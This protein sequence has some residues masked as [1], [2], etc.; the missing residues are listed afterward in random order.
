MTEPKVIIVRDK[1]E[2]VHIRV[3]RGVQAQ[4]VDIDQL[5]GATLAE[6][7]QTLLDALR[8]LM[9]P[10]GPYVEIHGEGY[11]PPEFSVKFVGDD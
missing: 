4:V 1:G 6:L 10:P 5:D 11:R 9:E 2:I 7:G 3:G 8:A